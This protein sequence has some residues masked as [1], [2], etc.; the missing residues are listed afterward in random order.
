MG[1]QHRGEHVGVGTGI[2]ER[3]TSRRPTATWLSWKCNFQ[4]K[5]RHGKRPSDKKVA[6]RA[7]EWAEQE[8]RRELRPAVT[9]DN[10]ELTA[11]YEGQDWGDLPRFT[12]ENS[13][14]FNAPLHGLSLLS[15]NTS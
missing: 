5:K 7:K 12:P 8:A 11:G 1:K 3:W 2:D 6:E 10:V 15:G 9:L 14:E 4:E 13:E